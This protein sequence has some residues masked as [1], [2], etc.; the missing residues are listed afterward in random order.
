MH[1]PAPSGRSARRALLIVAS[2]IIGSCVWFFLLDSDQIVAEES[3]AAAPSAPLAAKVGDA[4]ITERELHA[5]IADQLAE[6]ERRLLAR[7]LEERIRDLL[8][9]DAARTRGI[10]RAALIAE[11]VDAKLDLVPA[12]AVADALARAGEA[13]SAEAEQRIRRQLRLDAFCAELER[14]SDVARYA[15]GVSHRRAAVTGGRAAPAG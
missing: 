15:R 9:D 14:Q 4:A 13:S 1:E 7:A 3:R 8:L 6:T 10:D 2:A 5:A 11:E 12:G